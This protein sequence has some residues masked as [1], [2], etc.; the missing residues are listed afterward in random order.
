MISAA[1]PQ[2]SQLAVADSSLPFQLLPP[3]PTF[4]SVTFQAACSSS[5]KCGKKEHLQLC[6]Q[7]LI[8]NLLQQSEGLMTRSYLCQTPSVQSERRIR[9]NA[10]ELIS[11][12]KEWINKN[13]LFVVSGG[14]SRITDD[15]FPPT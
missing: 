12:T 1:C 11:L 10:V 15:A 7:L 2:V 9:R 6:L 14:P 8:Y 5:K 4:T 3:R 13:Q